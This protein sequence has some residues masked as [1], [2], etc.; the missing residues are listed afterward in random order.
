[1]YIFGYKYFVNLDTLIF[2]E[3]SALKKDTTGNCHQIYL[4]LGFDGLMESL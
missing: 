4:R 2:G 1:M 3:S